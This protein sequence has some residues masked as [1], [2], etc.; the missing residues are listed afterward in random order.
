MKIYHLTP[1]PHRK[2]R[3]CCHPERCT[4]I[5]INSSLSPLTIPVFLPWPMAVE[6]F[7]VMKCSE[8]VWVA[9]AAFAHGF[10]IQGWKTSKQASKLSSCR[11]PIVIRHRDL[12]NIWSNDIIYT[13]LDQTFQS[14]APVK[15][16]CLSI[17]SS[18]LHLR[19]RFSS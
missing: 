15:K 8:N 13:D 12:A 5:P 14:F 3:R 9:Q 4:C 18:K 7:V 11:F 16:A 17:G 6:P 1:Q 10:D 19:L 2:C